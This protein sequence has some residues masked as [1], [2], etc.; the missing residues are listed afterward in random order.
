[1]AFTVGCIL[2]AQDMLEESF[3]RQ[4]LMDGQYNQLVF[5]AT[6][7]R[8]RRGGGESILL[9]CTAYFIDFTADCTP[10]SVLLVIAAH[11]HRPPL[12]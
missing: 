8:G 11:V 9:G 12:H 4:L 10:D 1:M 5:I 2:V 3:R 6:Q 7:V